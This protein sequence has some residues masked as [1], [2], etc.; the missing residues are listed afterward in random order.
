[1]SITPHDES[2]S[3]R[4]RATPPAPLPPLNDATIDR[5]KAG[6]ATARDPRARAAARASLANAELL[7]KGQQDYR[8]GGRL[9]RFLLSFFVHALFRIRVENANNIPTGPAILAPNHLNHI[10]PFLVLA[11]THAH[12]YFYVFGDARTLYNKWWKQLLVR[13]IGGIIPL[14]RMW[15]E[16][17]AV[18]EAAKQGNTAVAAL[19]ADLERDIPNGTSIDILRQMDH[20]VAAIFARGDAM[21]IFPEGALGPQEGA[22]R[23]PLKRGTVRYALLSGMPLVPLG[24]IGSRDLFF[25]K[26]LTLR[27]GEPLSF[28]QTNRPKPRDEQAALDT[29][30]A[31][32]LDLLAVDYQE[33]QGIKLFRHLLNRM[34][35]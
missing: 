8:I 33:P 9:R 3:Q 4:R 23:L 29:L 17:T 30:Q 7:I 35:W 6:L 1:M 26:R 34:F 13:L 11:T 12:P 15:K 27:F 16:E 21:L 32:L 28:P 31:A 10:D 19:A 20:I 2:T 5:A 25:R 24:I 18:V 14:D 22:L